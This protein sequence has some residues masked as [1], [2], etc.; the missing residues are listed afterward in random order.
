MSH[1]F[2]LFGGGSG[3][4]YGVSEAA[5]IEAAW[6]EIQAQGDLLA[7]S[8][9][10]TPGGEVKREWPEY[11]DMSVMFKR[12][13]IAK[14]NGYWVITVPES[15]EGQFGLL[16][17]Q[18][19]NPDVQHEIKSLGLQEYA[20][21]FVAER[22]EFARVSREE[23]EGESRTNSQDMRGEMEPQDESTRAAAIRLVDALLDEK[24]GAILQQ[25]SGLKQGGDESGWH[26]K[27][28]GK[29][30]EGPFKNKPAAQRFV[31]AEVGVPAK[32]VWH[33]PKS[34]SLVGKLL[35]TGNLRE[36]ILR[37]LDN[38][39]RRHPTHYAQ[40]HV[41]AFPNPPAYAMDDPNNEWWSSQEARDFY[42]SINERTLESRE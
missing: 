27:I 15:D 37:R 12:A 39:R 21:E 2:I 26:V 16:D 5:S 6:K 41:A 17:A 31:D 38:L 24:P 40:L 7:Y 42:D 34:E 3:N 13:K 1:R 30:V 36:K 10:E 29:A 14:K 25:V 32:V 33:H 18:S 20:D 22:D 19:D 11:D 4:V 8:A 9:G 23:K 28:K 35:E